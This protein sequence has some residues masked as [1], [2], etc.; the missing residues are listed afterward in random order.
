MPSRIRPPAEIKIELPTDDDWILV[1]Q[2][3]TWGELRDSEVRMFKKL[4]PN[5]A[6]LDP[7]WVGITLV[8]AYLLQWSILGMDGQALVIPRSVDGMADVFRALDDYKGAEIME[9][10]QA[11][12]LARLSA[13]AEEKK[14][15][16]G[17]TPLPVTSDFVA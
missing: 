3:L 6:E 13:H 11:H 2:H 15:P 17:M 8:L 7:K 14:S 9:A 16:D 12:H 10:V 4:K 1:K 5:D